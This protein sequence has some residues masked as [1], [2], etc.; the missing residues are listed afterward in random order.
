MADKNEVPGLQVA[1]NIIAKTIE[2]LQHKPELSSRQRNFAL[3]AAENIQRA[4]STALTEAR[5][6]VKR[7]GPRSG[8]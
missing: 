3:L 5:M 4:V 1:M 8:E 7:R 6:S 2:N